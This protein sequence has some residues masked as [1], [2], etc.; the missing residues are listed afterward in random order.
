MKKAILVF[1]V[2]QFFVSNANSQEVKIIDALLTKHKSERN[3]L[4]VLGVGGVLSAITVNF[5]PVGAIVL[6]TSSSIGSAII[7]LEGRVK[8][9]KELE[10]IKNEF[11][12]KQK[13]TIVEVFNHERIRLD[14]EFIASD[15]LYT[16]SFQF[17]KPSKEIL[18]FVSV[19]SK[20]EVQLSI[21][22]LLESFEKVRNEILSSNKEFYNELRIEIK[23]KSQLI[24]GYGRDKENLPWM[25]L[26]DADSKQM[27]KS[28]CSMNYLDNQIN[29]LTR[30][31]TSLIEN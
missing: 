17:G 21:A 26:I 16:F 7:Y 6:G 30:A 14:K 25:Y 19:G 22:N 11:I 31:M 9:R 13:R 3:S 29:N 28:F 8:Y 2:F 4:Y 23:G 5:S 24:V 12:D 15:S 27:N 10:T 1:F 18:G 20:K